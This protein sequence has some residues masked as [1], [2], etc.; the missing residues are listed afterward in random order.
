MKLLKLIKPFGVVLS[1]GRTDISTL[2]LDPGNSVVSY[3]DIVV[4]DTK[5]VQYNKPLIDSYITNGILTI[6]EVADPL[7]NIIVNWADIVFSRVDPH[8]SQ[9][10]ASWT[11][12][13]PVITNVPVTSVVF[14]QGAYSEDHADGAMSSGDLWT[15]TANTITD[16]KLR[17]TINGPGYGSSAVYACQ[18]VVNGVTVHANATIEHSYSGS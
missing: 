4:E 17:V 15:L 6:L 14:T 5:S 16:G 18:L 9:P 8:A 7:P 10:V 12:D 3:S 13:W 1:T 11:A 2:T